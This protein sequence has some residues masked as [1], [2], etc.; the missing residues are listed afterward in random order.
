MKKRRMYIDMDGVLA[1]FDPDKSLEEVAMPGY[2]R[3]LPPMENVVTAIKNI[4][5]EHGNEY[6]VYALSS[7]LHEEAIADK[8]IWLD[9]E[10]PELAKENRIFVPYGRMKKDYIVELQDTDILLDDFSKNLREWHGVAIKLM[11]GINGTK[12]TWCGYSV[13]GKATPDVIRNT[14]IGIALTS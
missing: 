7:T 9:R 13:N 3:N 2:F 6:E 10:L 5:T 8:S 11:N 14:L 12:G 1:V 4:I